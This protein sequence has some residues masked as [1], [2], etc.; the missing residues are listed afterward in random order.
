MPAAA[1]FVASFI[2]KL[3]L[4]KNWVYQKTGYTFVTDAL[5]KIQP[6]QYNY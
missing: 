2:K 4:S 1:C 5:M 6:E 3:G